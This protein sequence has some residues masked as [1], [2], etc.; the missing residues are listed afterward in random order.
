M[1]Q[2]QLGKKVANYLDNSQALADYWQRAITPEQLQA[3]LNRMAAHTKRPEVLN[4]LFDAMSNDPFVIAE[5][6]VRPV[7]AQRLLT[8]VAGTNKKP[9]KRWEIG[10]K[11]HIAKVTGVVNTNYTLPTISGNGCAENIW[12]VTNTTDAPSGRFYHTAIWTGSEMIVWGGEDE[13]YM[14]FNSGARYDPSTD[15]WS[16]TSTA[17][18]PSP[19]VAHTA[20]WTGSEMI[21]WGGYDGNND[22][23]SGSRYDPITNSWTAMN[24]A[25]AP[26]G[27]DAHTAV[28]TGSEMIIWGGRGYLGEVNSGGRYNPATDSWSATSVTNAPDRRSFH[29]AVWTGSEMIVWG[30]YFH[31]NNG[32]QFF[33]TGGRYDPGMDSWTATNTATAPSER[34]EHIAVWTGNEM[35]VWGGGDRFNYFNTGGRYDP[36]TNSWAATDARFAPDG[37]RSHTA[38]WTGSEVI[39]W[40]GFG[41]SGFRMDTGGRYNPTTDGWTATTAINAP[42]G[43]AYH[44]AVW[45]GGEMIIW[46]GELNGFNATD[47]GGRYCQQSGPTP[48]PTPCTGRCEP[49]PRSRPAPHVRPTPR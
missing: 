23:N 32:N 49:T 14:P 44:A 35:I 19:R 28:W 41:D 34:L 37:R 33:N 43:R 48:T 31:D 16:V 18:A 7:L 22:L 5:C 9:L 6:L 46:G 17:D 36:I 10:E 29:T 40:G 45:T 38:V 21:V 27:R 39:V 47:T 2:T 12:T 20:V 15:D 26:E 8:N 3:E 24:T 42:G 30:G 13:D 1:S 11:N 4:E 25:N